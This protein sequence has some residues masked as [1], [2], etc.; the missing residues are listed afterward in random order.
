MSNKAHILHQGATNKNPSATGNPEVS[1]LYGAVYDNKHR[2][3]TPFL[4]GEGKQP[5]DYKR[6]LTQRAKYAHDVICL[7][8]DKYRLHHEGEVST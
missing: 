8:H 6:A 7:R 5:G 3:C 2:I 1:D 4:V